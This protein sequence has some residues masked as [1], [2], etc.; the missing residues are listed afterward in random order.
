MPRSPAIG[1]CAYHSKSE[2]QCSAMRVRHANGTGWFSYDLMIDP[3]S[4]SN[5]LGVTLYSGDQGRVFDV[6]VDAVTNA[7]ISSREPWAPLPPV[8][9]APS[10]RQ[11]TLV[12]CGFMRAVRATA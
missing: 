5:H 7:V 6:Y 4:A 11:K 9:K 12:S 2:R 1:A 3:A 8:A 10:P